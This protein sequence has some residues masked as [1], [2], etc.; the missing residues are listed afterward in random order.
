MTSL[1]GRNKHSHT[2]VLLVF[3]T[4]QTLYSLHFDEKKKCIN[5]QRLLRTKTSMSH[6]SVPQQKMLRR[7]V[8]IS[9]GIPHEFWGEL[10]MS[11]KVSLHFK[12]Y[13][14]CVYGKSLPFAQVARTLDSCVGNL[15]SRCSE[16]TRHFR[17]LSS[18]ILNDSEPFYSLVDVIKSLQHPMPT[19]LSG[20]TGI[21]SVVPAS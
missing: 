4:H 10:T 7:S 5:I 20:R 18:P 17:S 16:R 6:D 11:T 2:S 19:M 14:K 12:T 13:S 21:L 15:V 1:L 9:F 3:R 8:L